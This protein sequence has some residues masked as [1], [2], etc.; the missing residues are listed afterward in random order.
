MRSRPPSTSAAPLHIGEP[1]LPPEPPTELDVAVPRIVLDRSLWRPLAI[2]ALVFCAAGAVVRF[3]RYSNAEVDRAGREL[4]RG[5]F[6]Q[7]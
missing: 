3:V 7:P 5:G 2:A 1:V 6:G 4:V